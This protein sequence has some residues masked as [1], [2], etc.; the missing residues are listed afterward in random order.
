MKFTEI[1]PI[2]N[3]EEFTSK[4]QYQYLLDKQKARV[5]YHYTSGE[6][7]NSIINNE[8]LWI[9]KS[10]FL[11]D[12]GEI[13][14]TFDLLLEIIDEL[15]SNNPTEEEWDFKKFIKKGIDKGKFLAEAYILSLSTNY[16]SNLLWSNYSKN[17]GYNIGFSY[18]DIENT[19]EKSCENEDSTILVLSNEIIYDEV[20]QRALLINEIANLYKIYIYCRKNSKLDDFYEYSNT[21]VANI[22]FHSV[23]F[24]ANCFK[25]E[26]EFRIVIATDENYKKTG[27]IKCRFSNGVFIPY[28]DLPLV[29]NYDTTG[30]LCIE[31]ITIG[32][33]NNLDIAQ[34]GLRYFLNLHN[35]NENQVRIKKSQIPYRF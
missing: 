10:N 29:N 1:I 16:D 13:K 9:T 11:N 4:I 27:H 18:P 21:I 3:V 6:G 24:K 20:K 33:K 19:L 7:L 25:Q 32:P 31:S 34:D 35:L 28:I 26:E 15:M 17:D 8:S 22:F 5:L 2:N 30:K 14:Y 23:F 12:K